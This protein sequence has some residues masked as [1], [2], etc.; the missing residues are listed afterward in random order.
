MRPSVRP[1]VRLFVHLFHLSPFLIRFRFLFRFRSPSP[2]LTKPVLSPYR[3]HSFSTGARCSKGHLLEVSPKPHPDGT[4][5]TCN[6]CGKKGAVN[7]PAAAAAKTNATT[8]KGRLVCFS[9][10]FDLCL[11]CE[12]RGEG[13][14]GGTVLGQ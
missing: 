7:A 12:G 2:S 11:T 4:A 5:W 3:T 8:V 14:P 6:H 9:C 13:G 10:K 1:F